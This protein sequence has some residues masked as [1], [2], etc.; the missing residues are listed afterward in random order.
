[1]GSFYTYKCQWPSCN[2][3]AEA[4]DELLGHIETVHIPKERPLYDE[5]DRRFVVTKIYFISL[6]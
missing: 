4:L 2:V 6:I 5:T 1:M 3:K